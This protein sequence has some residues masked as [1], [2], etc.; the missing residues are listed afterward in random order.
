M[1]FLVLF[2][3]GR[4]IIAERR[5]GRFRCPFR[6]TQVSKVPLVLHCVYTYVKVCV[7]TY[8]KVVHVKAGLSSVPRYNVDQSLLHALFS[9]ESEDKSTITT[10]PSSSWSPSWDEWCGCCSEA[11]Y[12]PLYHC[13]WGFTHSTLRPRYVSSQSAEARLPVLAS[14]GTCKTGTVTEE[15]IFHSQ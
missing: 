6:S 7:Y 13:C 11:D 8:V 14:L 9:E 12:C 1:G 10:E 4:N 15:N 5:T 3:G 2:S